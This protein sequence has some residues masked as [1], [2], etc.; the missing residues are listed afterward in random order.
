MFTVCP[1]C[2]LKL[3][4]TASDLRVAQGYVRCGRCAN[5]FNALVGLSDE[6]LSQPASAQPD[7][8]APHEAEPPPPIASSLAEAGTDRAQAEPQDDTE[9]SEASL[10]F[11]AAATDVS[12]VFIEP[13]LDDIGSTGRSETI[14][15]RG[16]DE[17][18]VEEPAPPA[19]AAQDAGAQ[20]VPADAPPGPEAPPRAHSLEE[21]DEFEL[22]DIE[23][24]LESGATRDEAG[25]GG[26]SIG[27]EPESPGSAP[28]DHAADL[29]AEPPGPPPQRGHGPLAEVAE[30]E[31]AAPPPRHLGLLRAASAGLALLLAVQVVHHDR[32][33]LA[34]IGWLHRPLTALY[35]ALGMP[36]AAHW[37]V[38]A[39]EVRQLGAVVLPGTPAALTV[40]ASI[41]NT[42]ARAQPLPLL[43]VTVQDRFGNP[44]AARDVRPQAY[45]SAAR[46]RRG[47]LGAGERV[48]AQIAFVDPGPRVVGFEVDACLED[49][50][51]RIA[52]AH[53]PS[54]SH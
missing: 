47:S 17:L 5:V 38:R 24:L 27:S 12:E 49:A 13:R 26:P 4:V 16:E 53:Q 6:E 21:T 45:L 54:R 32:A 51:G 39:Y 40:R 46:A 41:E 23:A 50:A 20:D 1:K 33:R 14:I 52:C 19:A 31:A 37:N 30:F 7:A 18:P 34:A 22:A 15:L 35:A 2:S 29:P 11:D 10:E 28:A 9:L 25:N 44:V 8:S 48:D 43:R 36:F 42:A 3:V